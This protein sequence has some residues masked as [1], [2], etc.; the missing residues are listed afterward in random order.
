LFTFEQQVAGW[1]LDENGNTAQKLKMVK[2]PVVTQ[3]T[4]L[5]SHTTFFSQFTSNTTF[6]AGYLNGMC[7]F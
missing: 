3:E 5:W 4:C 6:C 1:G 2:M 7:S